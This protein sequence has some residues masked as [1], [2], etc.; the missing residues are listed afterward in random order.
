M[1]GGNNGQAPTSP[2]GRGGGDDASTRRPPSAEGGGGAPSPWFLPLLDTP[3]S[4]RGSLAGDGPAAGENG[5]GGGGSAQGQGRHPRH[6]PPCQPHHQAGGP[7]ASARAPPELAAWRDPNPGAAH[8]H[9][10]G[11]DARE[12][13]FQAAL[14]M[15][16]GVVSRDGGAGGGSGGG[17][18][19]PPPQPHP[20]PHR[21]P[22]H[23]PQPGAVPPGRPLEGTSPPADAGGGGGLARSRS[24]SGSGRSS[25]SSGGGGG[26][27]HPASPGD[28]PLPA[29]P[30]TMTRLLRTACVVFDF[31]RASG[32]AEESAVRRALGNTQDVSKGLRRLV[33]DRLVRRTGRGGRQSPF[34]YEIS[35]R[36]RSRPHW[37]S[38]IPAPEPE[39]P[40]P[41]PP[42]APPA[43]PVHALPPPSHP[44]AQAPGY[45][46]AGPP[47]PPLAAAA[48]AASAGGFGGVHY[49][50]PPGPGLGP[51]YSGGSGGGFGGQHP[52]PPP[53]GATAAGG[54]HPPPSYAPYPPAFPPPAPY[55]Y[56]PYPGFGGHYPPA[57]DGGSG[58]TTAHLYPHHAAAAHAAHH[59][60][61]HPLYAPSPG[62][63]PG[64]PWGQGP[65]HA[66]GGGGAGPPRPPGQSSAAAALDDADMGD[67]PPDVTLEAG[68]GRPPS[69]G[70]RGAMRARAATNTGGGNETW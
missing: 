45:G 60:Q 39:G 28:G 6:Q 55:G 70:T 46:G 26:G 22:R 58:P 14:S 53:L 50:H 13:A 32:P 34:M 11:E 8:A 33:A 67:W 4:L 12:A 1:E 23:P 25:R 16:P 56:H 57:L 15:M 52:Q 35:A 19:G 20:P 24:G 49:Q 41:A 38:A 64:G 10:P 65:L 21:P 48:Q 42:P 63:A 7:S 40:P 69:A 47:L 66:G 44:A 18:P 5:G 3:P 62:T 37:A 30:R 51:P 54:A 9:H 17:P 43:L 31:L 61:Q 2:T 36:A 68:G 29:A 27:G 59:H